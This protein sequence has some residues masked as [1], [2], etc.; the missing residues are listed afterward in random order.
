M[1]V[2]I[3]FFFFEILCLGISCTTNPLKEERQT[4]H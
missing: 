3:F 4:K 2:E 1:D